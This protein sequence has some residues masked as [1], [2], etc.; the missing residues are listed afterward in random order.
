MFWPENDSRKGFS[1]AFT[2]AV[3]VSADLEAQQALANRLDE[4]GLT[5]ISASTVGE[6]EAIL[7]LG[8]VSVIVCSDEL[9]DGGFRDIVRRT[10]RTPNK[11]P[12]VVF[13][14][15]ANWERYLSVLRS[16]AFD[17]V[18]YPPMRGE[19]ERVVRNALRGAWLESAKQA[20]PVA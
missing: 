15:F 8:F 16:G 18:L 12:V 3:I 19:I 20:V 1:M 6:A 14:R 17:Y 9:P 5:A 4:C 2:N 7:N 10:A 11:V 13:S